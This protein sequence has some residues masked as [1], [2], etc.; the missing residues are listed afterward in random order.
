MSRSSYKWIILGISF[1]NI[2]AATAIRFSFSIFFVA[3]LEEFRWSRAS[4]AG[5]FSLSALLL[6]ISSWFGG[7]LVDRFGT[8]KILIGGIIILSL[9]TIASG[10]IQQVW[11]LYALSGVLVAIGIAGIG[12]VPHSVLL[13]NWFSRSRG[14]AVG[15]AFSGL[16]VGILII[17]PVSQLLIS[18]FGWRIAYMILGLMVLALL[19]PLSCMVRDRPNH[20][21][22]HSTRLSSNPHTE[23]KEEIGE[24]YGANDEEGDWTLGRSMRTLPFW[25]ISLAFFIL[26]IGIFPVMIHQVAYIIDQGYSRILAASIFGAIGFLSSAGRLIF[27][28]LSDRIGREKAV[29]W[30]FACSITGIVILLLLPSLKSVFWLY[31]YALLFGAGFGARGPIGAAMM[32]DMYQGR[33]FGDIY[34]FIHVGN[35]IGGALGPW[36]GGY[37]Y[38]VTGS[39]KISFL[40]CIPVLVLACILF[41]MAG[42]PRR[43]K[44]KGQC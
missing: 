37:L 12:R 23:I 14:T 33:H 5:A 20:E 43:R 2:A 25:A 39:Y 1:M 29:T 38:D 17:G 15:I 10:R 13:S 28:P 24:L 18:S 30:S 19:L 26:P 34:G 36:L 27:G 4:I 22:G 7:R 11:H 32:V 9:S 42:W 6:G 41:W 40:T 3:I 21:E 8:R 31:L 44:T 35:G 16:G